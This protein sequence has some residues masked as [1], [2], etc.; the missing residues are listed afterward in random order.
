MDT[1]KIT[2]LRANLDKIDK[3]IIELIAERQ[4]NVDEIG[5]VK[6]RTNSPTRDFQREKQVM[7]NIRDAARDNNIDESIAQEI[8]TQIIR[9]S[10]AKQENQKL[11]QS[12]YGSDKKVLIIGGNGKMGLWFASFLASQGFNIEIS[13]IQAGE[14]TYKEVGDFRTLTLDHEFV[15]VATPIKQSANI[16]EE[17]IELEPSG[18]VLDISSIKSPLR[19]PLRK[20][21]DSGC[22]VASIHPMFGPNITLL[23][24]R[25]VIFIEVGDKEAV[26]Q[27]KLLFEPTMAERIDMKLEDHDR[28]IA[29]V[30]G[31]SHALNLVF[32]TVLSE[33]GEAAAVLADLSSTTFDAQLAIASNIAQE[34]PHLYFEIQKLN[35]YSDSTL[36]AMSDACQR[37]TDIVDRGNEAAF[38]RIM[39]QAQH[40]FTQRNSEHE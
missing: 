20:L 14:H 18:V 15:I 1:K 6:M 37:L 16:L 40:Y 28:L 9:T 7:E 24:N 27:V 21:A 3:Q 2:Q 8:F 22:Q 31:L 30:L 26:N 12:D 33:S 35:N 34:N 32:T 25:H 36:R 10:L 4:V 39:Q 17:L 13:D 19:L 5:N 29:Y 11:H 38:V 23:S